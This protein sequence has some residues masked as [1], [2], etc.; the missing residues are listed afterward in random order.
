MDLY[1]WSPI[2][3]IL[4]PHCQKKRNLVPPLTL[5][6]ILWDFSSSWLA[7]WAAGVGPANDWHKSTV[8]DRLC[9]ASPSPSTASARLPVPLSKLRLFEPRDRETGK[10]ISKTRSLASSRV[11]RCSP[12]KLKSQISSIHTTMRPPEEL[13]YQEN[14]QIS[15]ACKGDNLLQCKFLDR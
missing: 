14:L 1:F 6:F 13:Y 9:Q 7:Q 8:V 11:Q 2:V 4:A 15:T 12:C 5:C 3:S 10:G